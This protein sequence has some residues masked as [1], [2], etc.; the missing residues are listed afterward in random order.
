MA[1]YIPPLVENCKEK[2]VLVDGMHRSYLCLAAGTTITAVHL[3]D[4]QSP[5]PFDPIN[6]RQVNIVQERPLIE[7]RYKNLQKEYYRDLG[8]VGIDG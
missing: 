1:L 6:W 2:P 4:V 8:Y 7:E 3:I 5:L